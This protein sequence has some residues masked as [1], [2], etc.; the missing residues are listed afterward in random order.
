MNIEVDGNKF[1]ID[2][3]PN[4]IAA[5]A[6]RPS[7]SKELAALA[8][9]RSDLGKCVA[10]L[11]QID[12]VLALKTEE[13]KTIADGLMLAVIA[14]AFKC[15]GTSASR[16][17]LR[18]EDIT[19]TDNSKIAVFDYFK[20]LRNKHVIHDEN[21]YSQSFPALIVN[22][23]NEPT[24]VADVLILAFNS[25][26]LDQSHLAALRQLV[27]ATKEWIENRCEKLRTEMVAK[28]DKMSH[29][30]LMALGDLVYKAPTASDVQTKR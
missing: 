28:Y 23:V 16:G 5:K 1:R 9:H 7:D 4:A 2:G 25:N 27:T 3:Y 24:K 29:Q 17:K 19:G 6:L 8:L 26:Y 15:F 20:N 21:S 10:W 30:D 11:D 18:K 14:K 22:N 13:G 12:K